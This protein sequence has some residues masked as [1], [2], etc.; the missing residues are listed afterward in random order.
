LLKKTVG[1]DCHRQKGKAHKDN[2]RKEVQEPLQPPV[3]EQVQTLAHEVQEPLQPPVLEQVQTL[4]H[5][6]AQEVCAHLEQQPSS[7]QL[8]F[9]F[10]S[11]F[12]L[13]INGNSHS[14]FDS[15]L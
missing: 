5:E 15:V 7:S 10:A 9:E 3:L 4:A 13:T 1:Y 11:K 14:L 6:S 8:L 2:G 12:R